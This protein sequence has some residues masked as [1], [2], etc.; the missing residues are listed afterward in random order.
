MATAARTSTST[1]PYHDPVR[2][3]TL[4]EILCTRFEDVFDALGVGLVRSS[5]MFYGRCPIHGGSNYSALNLYTQGELV[6]GYW[7]CNTKKCHE[8]FRKTILGFIR[9]VLSAQRL[10]W[11]HLTERQKVFPF[12]AT[13]DWCCDLIGQKLTDIKVDYEDVEKRQFAAKAGILNRK[14]VQEASGVPREKVRRFLQI[15]SAY[16][17]E[18][19]WAKETLDRYD[20]GLYPATGRPL[21]NRVVVPVYDNDHRVAIG[22]TGR[23]VFPECREC[24]CYHERICPPEEERHFFSKWKNHG[25]KKESW[26]Y[27][28]W[29][30]KKLI[31]QSGVVCLCESPGDVWRLTEAG[32]RVGVGLFGTTLSDQQ[33]VILECSG[34]MNVVL[35]LNNDEAGKTG[36]E[37]IKR[38]LGRCFRVVQP[39]IS[40]NDIGEMT[41]EQVRQEILPVLRQIK[42][43]GY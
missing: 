26:L 42:E 31:Q 8:T 23:S 12:N 2:L 9:G 6:P 3:T 36:A 1:N 14:P 38:R 22:F 20:V 5:K 39:K 41:V 32:I 16:F 28:F 10:G 7:R 21:S 24:G 13:V 15:P 19:G 25:F 40:T 33:Q 35:L 4:Q 17:I 18:R 30:A 27:N 43:R 34:S 11:N 37:D 29:F